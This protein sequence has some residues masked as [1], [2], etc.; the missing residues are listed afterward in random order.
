VHLRRAAL[1]TALLTG[2]AITFAGACGGG[3]GGAAGTDGAPTTGTAGSHVL[4]VVAA[5]D[6]WGSLAAQL[7]GDH[8]VVTSIVANPAVDPH[9]Y[10]P[11]ASD[12]RA[13]A[14][15]DEVVVNG[16][17]YDPWARKLV[18]ANGG[19]PTVLDVG[20]LVAVPA[21]ANP[22]RW[23]APADVRAVIDRL[24]A[25]YRRLDPADDAPFVARHDA[26]VRDD[27][28]D[29]TRLVAEI[30]SRYAGTPV[31][32]SESIFAPL[33]DALG[34]DLV[35]PKGFLDAVSEGNDPTAADKAAV[36]HQ[37]ADRQ[38]VVLVDNT[39][40]LTPD[41]QR[42][43]DS[44]TRQGIAVVPVTETLTPPTATFQDWQ[45]GQLRALESA[46]AKATGK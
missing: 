1:P 19:H 14:R 24:T 44:A 3:G 16:A 31:G 35:T 4:R 12:A 29:Y 34:L 8:V 32:A 26:F 7:G 42:L 6:M 20:A 22:H 39:Q 11:S 21:G 41:V 27:L 13:I 45:V 15:A 9:G 18:E 2:L 10:E 40:N 38:L 25:D 36:D 5:E 23:Y 33:A 43:V 17:G 46:L 30:R 37:I 28:A